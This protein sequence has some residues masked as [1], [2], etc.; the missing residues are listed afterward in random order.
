MPHVYDDFRA[1]ASRIPGAVAAEYCHRSGLDQISFGELSGLAERAARTLAGLGVGAGDRCAIL[2]ENHYRWFV[3]YLGVLR[4]GAVAVPLDTAYSA[5]QVRTVLRDSGARAIVASRRHLEA[6]LEAAAGLHTAPGVL[7]LDGAAPGAP[8]LVPP[9]AD[10]PA[11]PPPACPATEAD[12]AVMLY[13]SGTTSDPKG[14]VLTHGNLRAERAGALGVIR[15]DERDAILAILPLFHALAQIANLLLPLT[16][17]ARVVF[18]ETVNSAEMMRAFRERRIT[19]FCV[20][21]QF[22]YLLHQRISQRVAASG[23][24]ARAAYRMLVALNAWSRSSAGV[25]LGPFLFRQAHAAVGGRMRIMVCGGSRFDPKVGRDLYGMGFNIVQAYGLTEC[26]GAATATRIGDPHVD[27]V[28]PPLDGVDIRIAPEPDGPHDREH[29]DGE[30]LIRGPIVM[31]GYHNRPDVNAVA[32]AEGWLHTGDLGYLDRGGRLVITGRKKE[33]IVLASGK[34]IYPEDVEAHYAASPFIKDICV[35]GIALPDEP[36]AERLHAVVV[37]DLDVMRERRIVNLREI[38][39]FDIESL[40][41]ALPHHKRVLS[42]DVWMEDLPR[43]T[44]RKL[45]RHE[46]ERLYREKQA[47]AQD[48]EEAADVSEADQAWAADPEVARFLAIIRAAAPHGI[49]VRP[50]SN[51]ELD[52][53]LDSMERVELLSTLEHEVGVDVP[54]EVAQAILTVGQLVDAIRPAAAASAVGSAVPVD[55]W[56]RVLAA[57]ESDPVLA[58]VLVPKPV[59]SRVAYA[60]VRT[61]HGLARALLGLRVDGR[62]HLPGEATYVISPNHQSY[63]DAFLL[64]GTLPYRTFRRLFFVGASEYFETLFMRRLAELM[65]VVPVDPDANLLRAMQAGAF[66]LRR[67]LVLTLFPEGERSP[68]GA[69]RR[70]KKGA[71]IT[72]L[73][74]QAPIVPVA[75]HGFHE[76]WPRGSGLRWR[77]LLPWSRTRCTIRFG[78]PIPPD[79]SPEGTADRYEHHTTLLK[80]AV[81]ELWDAL[82]RER[83]SRSS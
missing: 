72:A 59:F 7:L 57:D 30:I 51:L 48:A 64:V 1:V 12:P 23:P 47:R 3:A 22:Y 74:A 50:D 16:A 9:D 46:I 43:T 31:A 61:L 26:S 40:S 79:R 33:I 15:V 19:A 25:N 24:V 17:G 83:P 32:L 73:Q 63:L 65:N 44:T 4:L 81:V 6:A 29:Q 38:I 60:V 27:T 78:A 5:D 66:G 54:D 49:A 77:A 35:L 39:R 69:P 82:E 34:N 14:V 58:A 70:F 56:A 28:G 11:S 10:E 62:E 42:F 36:A 8:A 67:G 45:K 68:D 18:L 13:T 76:I 55:P 20:V 2:A 71:A 53:G 21:P 52:L 37:P 41:L 75:L 80:A